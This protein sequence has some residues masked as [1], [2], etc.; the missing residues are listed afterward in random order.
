MFKFQMKI[1]SHFLVILL[2]RIS[3]TKR[4]QVKMSQVLNFNGTFLANVFPRRNSKLLSAHL[5]IILLF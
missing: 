2:T 3:E 1:N 4:F 5:N